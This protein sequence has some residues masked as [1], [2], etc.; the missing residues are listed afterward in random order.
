MAALA[1]ARFPKGEPPD[2]GVSSVV[3]SDP[4]STAGGPPESGDRWVENR[5]KIG[6]KHH[7][8]SYC[9][10]RQEADHDNTLIYPNNHIKIGC[11]S[12]L[13]APFWV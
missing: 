5:V 11:T 7:I 9:I 2:G 1:P 4:S 6:V 12:G 3:D 10:I 8:D 13:E